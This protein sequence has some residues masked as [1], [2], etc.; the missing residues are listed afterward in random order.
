MDG[1]LTPYATYLGGFASATT[2]EVRITIPVN[3]P[4]V[5]YAFSYSNPGYGIRL[6]NEGYILGDLT[7]DYIYD[8][9]VGILD[10]YNGK[11]VVTP[12][13]PNG[14]YAYFMT[15]DGSGNP[16]YPYA[17]GPQYYG[18]P[19]FEGDAVPDQVSVFPIEAEGDIVLNTDGTV[20]YIKMTKNGDNFFGAAKAVILGGEGTGALATPVTQTVTGLSL[21]NEGRSYAT[22]P[23]LIF[24]GGGGQDLSLIHI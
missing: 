24:E 18:T 20:S 7:Q 2:R 6:V 22:P 15:E 11:Y 19:I 12:E 4:R 10:Q 8:A 23:N 17:I 1:V 3:S 21:L 14:T 16:V 5:A 13:Y 9:S